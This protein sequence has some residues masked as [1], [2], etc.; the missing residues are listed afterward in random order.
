MLKAVSQFA[1]LDTDVQPASGSSEP[2]AAAHKLTSTTA[3]DGLLLMYIRQLLARKP[4]HEGIVVQQ[5]G[6]ARR[7]TQKCV[8]HAKSVI[9][10]CK[11]RHRNK[12]AT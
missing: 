8:I 12:H 6:R 4:N 9:Q 11:A 10:N 2:E 1:R 7:G 3:E 5:T